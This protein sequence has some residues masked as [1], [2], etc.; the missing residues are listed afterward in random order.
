[1]APL[2]AHAWPVA[3]VVIDLCLPVCCGLIAA[4]TTLVRVYLLK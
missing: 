1:M 3:A 4:Y 2:M